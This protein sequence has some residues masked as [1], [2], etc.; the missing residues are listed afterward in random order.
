M[1]S[2]R[3]TETTQERLEALPHAWVLV[4]DADTDEEAVYSME[5]EEED[6]SHVVLAFED[7]EEAEAYAKSLKD[8]DEASEL[9][10]YEN[11]EASVQA[12]DVEALVVTS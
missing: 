6:N 12:L 1:Q 8:D 9:A 4:F 11:A 3:E 7:R 2:V 10:V 5:V